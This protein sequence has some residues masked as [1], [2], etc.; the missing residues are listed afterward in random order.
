MPAD[1]GVEDVGV[2]EVV[3]SIPKEHSNRV[4]R[5]VDA[6]L[7]DILQNLSVWHGV[8][9]HCDCAPNEENP[10]GKDATAARLN[11]GANTD[12]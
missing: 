12:V 8:S 9:F 10:R 5:S 4:F 3:R 2:V 11:L 7:S 1:E 6:C